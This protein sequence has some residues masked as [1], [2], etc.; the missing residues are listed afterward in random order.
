MCGVRLRFVVP[1]PRLAH[2]V[3]S[4]WLLLWQRSSACNVSYCVSVVLQNVWF[5][6]AKAYI[7]QDETIRFVW[8][9]HTFDMLD[10]GVR[11]WGGGACLLS[12]SIFAR[13]RNVCGFF[14]DGVWNGKSVATPVCRQCVATLVWCVCVACV[15]MLRMWGSLSAWRNLVDARAKYGCSHAHEVAPAL[16]GNGVVV[17]HSP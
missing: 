10:G 8:Q 15:E 14:C 16:H 1:F 7:L 13:C 6:K 4:G 17:A 11:Q 5:R 9:E 3:C 2:V 12:Y